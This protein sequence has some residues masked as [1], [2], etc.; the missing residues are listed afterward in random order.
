MCS[1]CGKKL[2][3]DYCA[4]CYTSNSP[5]FACARCALVKYCGKTCQL[6]H[7]K[8]DHKQQCI[9]IKERSI[10]VQEK[11]V[12]D[13][14]DSDKCC[15]CLEAV[16]NKYTSKHIA[17]NHVFH[18]EC[19]N[20]WFKEKQCCPLCNKI[21]DKNNNL[22]IEYIRAM[23]GNNIALI[24]TT[25]KKLTV[26]EESGDILNML[27]ELYKL[28]GMNVKAEQI[29]KISDKKFPNDIWTYFNL[30]KLYTET[31]QRRLARKYNEKC[32]QLSSLE[33]NLDFE[34]VI[35][36]NYALFLVNGPIIPEVAQDFEKLVKSETIEDIIKVNKYSEDYQKVSIEDKEHAKKL[37]HRALEIDPKYYKAYMLLAK[38]ATNIEE[39]LNYYMFAIKYDNNSPLAHYR[40]AIILL[41]LNRCSEAIEYYNISLKLDKSMIEERIIYSLNLSTVGDVEDGIQKLKEILY[42]YPTCDRV[43]KLIILSNGYKKYL[44]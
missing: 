5:L 42:D 17:C 7:W 26:C 9:P 13:Y 4:N 16:Q 20:R 12:A 8:N 35:L 24:N 11:L 6:Q 10:N 15:I 23:R 41:E 25:I 21:Y 32:L 36:L 34:R 19:I 22:C 31:N 43:Q 40:V 3:V 37:L 18:S 44:D 1:P 28:K 38:I 30:A 14:T 2:N 33:K 27:S 39:Q 29:L